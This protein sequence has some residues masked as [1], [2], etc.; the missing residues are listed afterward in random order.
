M[1]GDVLLFGETNADY[2]VAVPEGRWDDL[3][4]A[5]VGVAYDMIGTTGGDSF[6]VGD[7]IDVKLSDLEAAHERDLFEQHAPEGEHIG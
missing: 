2:I 3:Q 4:D 5:L 7:L 1:R 6:R